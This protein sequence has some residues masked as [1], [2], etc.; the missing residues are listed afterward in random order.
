MKEVQISNSSPIQ[1]NL[2]L[3][4][5]QFV[6]ILL[7]GL[8][9][10]SFQ[11]FL[12]SVP[13]IIRYFD[14]TPS[15]A[16]L[17]IS[18]S[19]TSFA[20]ASL[21]YGRLADKFGSRTILL[22]GMST[23]IIGSF[24]C[25]SA[26]SIYVVLIGRILQPAGGA[27]GIIA[28]RTLVM[29]IYEKEKAASVMSKLIAAM[30]IA[31]LIGVPLGGLLTDHFG[32]RSNF[33]VI[34]ITA[35][36]ALALV[37]FI[38]PKSHHQ[39]HTSKPKTNLLTDYGRLVKNPLFLGNTLQ[40]G[41]AM[42]AFM[43]FMATSPIVLTQ[44]F[45]LSASGISF[46]LLM[47]SGSAIIGNL[48]AS[49]IPPRYSLIQRLLVGSI[50]ACSGS[51]IAFSLS[52]LN[53]WTLAALIL[54]IMLFSICYGITSPAAQTGAMSAIKELTGTA[55]GLCMFISMILASLSTQLVSAFND[56]T[57]L[58]ITTSLMMLAS[59]SLI[60]AFITTFGVRIKWFRKLGACDDETQISA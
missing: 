26:Q 13:A 11:I 60:A 14:A 54:P 33:I 23:L 34:G 41:F 16:N 32:W 12:P 55:A 52:I 3:G 45:K 30:M 40:F 43:T 15:I 51:L 44:T 48:L 42:S 9:P 31:P 4:L 38:V 20:I 2:N 27:A 25:L 53:V 7:S 50:V 19:L 6:L 35:L 39:K 49:R 1:T 36:F 17:T 58:T 28:A 10:T 56:G 22:F 18:L 59:L 46:A 29:T 24:I 8:G 5:L 47:A 37:F 21:V 57:P